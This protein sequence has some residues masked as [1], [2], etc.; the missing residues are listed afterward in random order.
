MRPASNLRVAGS[1]LVAG[2]AVGSATS[3]AANGVWMTQSEEAG[4]RVGM[5]TTEVEQVLGRPARIISYRYAPG[6]T[7]T[8]HVAGAP[9][10]MTDFDVSYGA[11]GKVVYASERVLGGAGAR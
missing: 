11:D 7:W 8:Y 6:P 1:L 10:G 2:L 9:F 5:A 4:I 3:E